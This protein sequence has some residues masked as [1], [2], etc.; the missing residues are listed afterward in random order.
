MMLRWFVASMVVSG[1]TASCGHPGATPD[2]H[3]PPSDVAED[4]ID[5]WVVLDAPDVLDAPSD[6]PSDAPIDASTDASLDL[7]D[8]QFVG[9]EMEN[10]L[11][12]TDDHVFPDNCLVMEGC[13]SGVGNRRLLRFDTV[14]A[15]LGTRDLI[16][17]VPPPAGQ[18]NDVFVWSPCHM[19]HHVA[20][21][22]SYELVDSQGVVVTGHKQAFCLEDGEQ[23]VPGAPATGYSC[24][25]QGISR[26]WADIYVRS[27]PCQWIDVTGVP[28]GA[29]TLRIILNPVHALSESDY[30]NNVFAV[31]V[32]I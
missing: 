24:D 29:Y 21:Y 22:T 12:V 26:G 15:N 25:N 7:P 13:V 19:H 27:L 31:P 14:T 20:N 9:R 17:G 18:S 5:A 30:T 2:A 3:D 28:S 6:A 10:T 16:V 8:L 1:V 4:S 11:V 23:V 32:Q